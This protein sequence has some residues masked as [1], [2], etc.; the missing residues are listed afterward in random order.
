MRIID[1]EQ[2]SEAWHRLR[3]KSIGSSDA[4]VLMSNNPW[5]TEWQLFQEKMGLYHH[6]QTQAMTRGKEL[7]PIALEKFENEVNVNYVPMVCQSEERPWQIASLDG[8]S[9][10]IRKVVEIKCSE[11]LYNEA[12][13]GIIPQHYIDQ[14]Q[15]QLCVTGFSICY[16]YAY[17]EGHGIA[18]QIERDEEYIAN[19]IEKEIVFYQRMVCFDPPEPKHQ[20][21]DEVEWG[22]DADLY[23]ELCEKEIAI[24][25]LKKACK[26]RLISYAKEK[27]SKG[28]GITLTK[29]IKPGTLNV[30]SICEDYKV[31]VEKYRS[32][33]VEYWAITKEKS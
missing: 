31:D 16:Y 8:I 18:I 33:P 3:R 23:I 13:Q 21:R 26:D 28:S 10:P 9:I 4:S 15:H 30:R 19:I 7:E 32:Q 17:W 2:G 25:R 22:L 6:K 27:N 5:K 1:V 29:V 20:L 11:K 12:K 24:D 14:M